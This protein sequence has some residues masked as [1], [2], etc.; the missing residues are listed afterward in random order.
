MA[1]IL[2]A[3]SSPGPDVM[4]LQDALN[5]AA[6]CQ[7]Q[8]SS[9]GPL[10]VDGIFG[11]KTQQRVRE[12]QAINGMK[13]DG[14]VSPLT[15]LRIQSVLSVVPGLLVVRT[16]GGGGPPAGGGKGS[17]KTASYLD[18]SAGKSSSGADPGGGTGSGKSQTASYVYGYSGKA[19]AGANAGGGM[20]SGKGKTASH[21]DDYAGKDG[22]SEVGWGWTTALRGS[23]RHGAQ[24]RKGSG[25]GSG[26]SGKGGGSSGGDDGGG[27]QA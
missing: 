21:V 14:V 5:V 17:G 18:D 24:V 20:G 13:P 7:G 3:G 25:G 11:W 2:L 6:S 15:W 4:D 27:K 22:A 10:V 1:S 12:F 8:A 16:L 23:F 19:S 26:S 9:F